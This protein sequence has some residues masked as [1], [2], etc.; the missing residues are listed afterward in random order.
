MK[1]CGRAVNFIQIINAEGDVRVCGWNRNN[2]IGNLLKQSMPEIMHSGEAEKIREMLSVGNFSYCDIDN[3][4]YLAND[5]MEDITIDIDE[6]PDYPTELYLG[7]E[8]VCNYNCT[9]CT[10]YQHIDATRK[11]DYSKNYDLLELRIKEMLPYVHCISANGR[12]ELFASKRILRLLQTWEP[13]TPAEKLSVKLETNGSMF[14]EEHWKQI[15]NLGK[16]NLSV[17]ITVMSFHERIYQHLSGTKLPITKIVKNLKFV[18]KLREEGVINYLELATVLQ[19][20]NFREMPEFTKRCIEEF[21][22]DVVRIRPIVPGGR[23]PE[24]IQWFMDVRNPKHPYYMQYREIMEHPIFKD[25]KVLLWSGDI[26]SS[27][28]DHPGIKVETIQKAADY[29][30]CTDERKA[31]KNY[32]FVG[33]DVYVYG[34]GTLGKLMISIN[35]RKLKIKAVIDKYSQINIWKDVPVIK[36][37]D[38]SGKN[39]FI[40]VTTY[41]CFEEIKQEL[42]SSGFIGKIFSLFDLMKEE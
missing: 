41:G 15:E 5:R 27:L 20:E 3:C 37:Q 9:C 36:L 14:D 26:P 40:I 23:Y 34:I 39:G 12:G 42:I 31:L 28:G 6:I 16:Y 17:Y 30:L 10:S 2:I 35:W 38:I 24:S 21:G 7:Y 19:E 32:E 22:A 18:K 33:T 29:L 13:V 8:G 4:P 25:P 11:N 1:I